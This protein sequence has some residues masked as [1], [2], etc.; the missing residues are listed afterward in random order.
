MSKTTALWMV[1]LK[2]LTLWDEPPQGIY[3]KY[4]AVLKL[5]G[6]GPY[7]M[8]LNYDTGQ[9]PNLIAVQEKFKSSVDYRTQVSKWPLYLK[10]INV[11]SI[12][13]VKIIKRNYIWMTKKEIGW[14]VREK[15]FDEDMAL[16][17]HLVACW[18]R[19]CDIDNEHLFTKITV[20]STIVSL[21][22][23]YKHSYNM[24]S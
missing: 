7:S 13:K 19:T 9:K 17:R 24:Y 12:L 22:N 3:K 15:K 20:K 2:Q 18:Y 1:N 16:W 21:W 8:F 4:I 23:D 14:I 11:S 10:R 5:L 6:L